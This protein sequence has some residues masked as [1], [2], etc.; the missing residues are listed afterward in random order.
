MPNLSISVTRARLPEEAYCN[1]TPEGR[2]W[3]VCALSAAHL[4]A[5]EGRNGYPTDHESAAFYWAP[6][7]GAQLFPKSLEAQREWDMNSHRVDPE[8]IGAVTEQIVSVDFR[9]EA[10]IHHLTVSWKGHEISTVQIPV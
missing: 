3:P 8:S 5:D 9:D 1:A 4:Q 10:Q 7:P 6:L 2:D